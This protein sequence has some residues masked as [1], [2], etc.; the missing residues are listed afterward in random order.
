[1]IV[2]IRLLAGEF[3]IGQPPNDVS[4]TP[5][6]EAIEFR[7]IGGP[8]LTLS[9][10]SGDPEAIEV[11]GNRARFLRPGRFSVLASCAL[12]S[13]PVTV[14]A[15]DGAIVERIRVQ[16]G[17][18]APDTPADQRQRRVI[19]E[20][21]KLEPAFDGTLETLLRFNLANYGGAKR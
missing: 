15:Y 17:N 13:V 6:G 19:R 11:A 14:L 8:A 10:L 1:M 21:A 12:A 3:E 9:Y 16:G 7:T 20:L 5:V 4:I 2:D 18:A